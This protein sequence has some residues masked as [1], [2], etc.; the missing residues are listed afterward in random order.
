MLLGERKDRPRRGGGTRVTD[1]VPV[2]IP[3]RARRR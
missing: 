1:L 2:P 3:V